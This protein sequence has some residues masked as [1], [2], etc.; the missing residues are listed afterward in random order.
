LLPAAAVTKMV[1]DWLE[2]QEEAAAAVTM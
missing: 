1:A 2:L